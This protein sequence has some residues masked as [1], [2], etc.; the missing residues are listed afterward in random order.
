MN[1]AVANWVR[2]LA[3]VAAGIAAAAL[4]IYV[5]DTDDAPG[6][7]LLGM[8]LLVG[9][10]VAAVRMVRRTRRRPPLL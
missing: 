2:S 8:L 4:G 6:A 7:A 1:A 3:F 10:V 5:G 9:A